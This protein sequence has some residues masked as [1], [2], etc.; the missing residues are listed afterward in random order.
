[1]EASKLKLFITLAVLIGTMMPPVFCKDVGA[2]GTN[3]VSTG[4]VITSE[5][6][7]PTVHVQPRHCGTKG[8]PC[9]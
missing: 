2:A 9:E 6:S 1:M 8:F 7:A 3:S 5:N 4:K